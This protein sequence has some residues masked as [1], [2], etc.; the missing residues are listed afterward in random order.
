VIGSSLCVGSLTHR[1]LEAP[2]HRFVYPLYM[3]LVDLDEL[4]DLDRRLRLLGHNRARPVGFR[5]AD[6]LGASARPV[7][8]KVEAFLRSQGIEPPG[9]RV[10]LLTHPRVFGH[11]F[12][13]VSFFYCYEP[14]GALVARVAEVNNTFG[15][16]HAYAGSTPAWSDKKVMH[17]SPFFSMAGSYLWNLPEPGPDRV[18]ARVDLTREGRTLLQARLTLRPEPLGDRAIARALVRYPLMTLKVVAAIHFEALRLWRMGAR[19]FPN[20]TYDPVSAR[21]EVA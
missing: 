9:G 6:H 20:P 15:D 3:L 13:P 14:G 1:R 18:E 21:R 2:E 11:V 7:R 8:D 17:V 16:S 4:P 5:D 19:V 12:N 10:L